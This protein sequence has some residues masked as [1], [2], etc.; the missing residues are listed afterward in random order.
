VQEQVSE[1]ERGIAR[2]R[3]AK[4]AAD[5]RGLGWPSID[6]DTSKDLDQIEVAER[7]PTG[8]RV[9]VAVGDVAAAV[10]KG[11]PIDEHAQTIRAFMQTTVCS[12]RFTCA[13]NP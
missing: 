8:I 2:R 13:R 12:H 1:I 7:V 4:R 5:L 9:H 11:S 10:E 6:N 3:D